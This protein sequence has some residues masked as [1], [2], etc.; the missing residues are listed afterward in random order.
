MATAFVLVGASGSVAASHASLPE[1]SDWIAARVEA[2]DVGASWRIVSTTLPDRGVVELT[3]PPAAAASAAQRSFA[4]SA[5]KQFPGLVVVN[6]QRLRPAPLACVYPFCDPPLRGG[7]QIFNTTSS[8]TG[9]FLARSRSDSKLY[10]MTAGHCGDPG[11]DPWRTLFTGRSLHSIGH[12]HHAAFGGAYDV[13]IYRVEN[14]TGWRAR[15]WVLVTPSAQTQANAEYPIRTAANP[16]MG[17]RVCVTGSWFGSSNCGFVDGVD[18]TVDYGDAVVSGLVSSTLCA[19]F[20]DSGG[21]VLA[22]TVAYGLVSGGG[23][24]CE[25]YFEPAR[26]AET[27]MGVNISRDVG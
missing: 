19:T 23:A 12:V 16:T 9:G 13:S 17:T 11:P 21:P 14:P 1:V 20:G 26:T 6:R 25:T 15:A 18:V 8:C 27:A 24:S 22:S 5:V 7:I 2:A 4:A 3:V 10:Q